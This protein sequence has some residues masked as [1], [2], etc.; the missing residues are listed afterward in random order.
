MMSPLGHYRIVFGVQ[1]LPADN[2]T[3]WRPEN[4]ALANEGARRWAPAGS[5]CRL[6]I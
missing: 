6:G 5:G 3:C 4:D 1:E 2:L